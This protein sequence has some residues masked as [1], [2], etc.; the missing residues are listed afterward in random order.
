MSPMTELR[1]FMT[2]RR[3]QVEEELEPLVA[4][5]NELRAEMEKLIGRISG[6]SKELEELKRAEQAIAGE[7]IERSA[8]A[9][10]TIKEAVLK[11]LEQEK[12]GLTAQQILATINQKFFDGGIARSSLSPQLSRLNHVDHKITFDGTLWSL[13]H[14]NDEG[15]AKAEP[16]FLD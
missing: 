12:R 16:S 13:D 8:P 6:L 11:V 4:R 7:E 2:Q 10:L 1:L 3:T 5:R 9:R 15:P 14:Q